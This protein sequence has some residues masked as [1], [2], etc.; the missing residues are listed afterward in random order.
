MVLSVGLNPGINS[1]ASYNSLP[2]ANLSVILLLQSAIRQR[3]TIGN[4]A[5]TIDNPNR[6]IGNPTNYNRLSDFYNRKR[7]KL[8][9]AI[10]TTFRQRRIRK[11]VTN[12]NR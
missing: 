11:V 12:L 5:K 9:T 1:R 8:V 2:R 6:T 4:P 7:C 10:S 3:R